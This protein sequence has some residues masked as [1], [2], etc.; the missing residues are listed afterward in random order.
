MKLYVTMELRESLSCGC[1]IL[2]FLH[3]NGLCEIVANQL[4]HKIGE[5]MCI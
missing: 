1:D 2:V 4:N 5:E 3:L